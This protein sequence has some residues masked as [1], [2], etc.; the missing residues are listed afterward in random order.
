MDDLSITLTYAE[1]LT[2]YSSLATISCVYGENA[3][4]DGLLLSLEHAIDIASNTKVVQIE[5]EA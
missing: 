2:L 1:L 5:I 3:V 4:R